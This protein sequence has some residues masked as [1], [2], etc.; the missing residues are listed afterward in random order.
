MSSGTHGEIDRGAGTSVLSTRLATLEPEETSGKVRELL[1]GLAKRGEEP[2]PMV[3]TMAN[4][5]SLHRA[6]SNSPG[7]RLEPPEREPELPPAT[8]APPGA[9]RR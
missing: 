5:R 3:R 9:K 4:A 2:G 7:R 6:T 8:S 1:D